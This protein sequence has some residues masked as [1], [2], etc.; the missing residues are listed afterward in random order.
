MGKK[1]EL[2]DL[3]YRIKVVILHFESRKHKKTA[4]F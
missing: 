3:L 1:K 4:L 2:L